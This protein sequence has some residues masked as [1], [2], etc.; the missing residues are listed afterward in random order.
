[1][2]KRLLVDFEVSR[3]EESIRILKIFNNLN[4]NYYDVMI[5]YDFSLNLEKS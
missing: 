1:M 3:M 5:C 2:I 4:I